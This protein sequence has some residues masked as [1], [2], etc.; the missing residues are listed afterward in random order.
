MFGA[1]IHAETNGL[2]ST[3]GGVMAGSLDMGG[4]DIDN[5][6]I[7]F[8]GN[9]LGGAVVFGRLGHVPLLIRL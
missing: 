7:E 9:G 3:N 2:L 6:D 8:D 5:S 1:D 4:N